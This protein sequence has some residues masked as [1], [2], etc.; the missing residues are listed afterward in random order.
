MSA[1]HAPPSAAQAV[2]F[3]YYGLAL[4][5]ALAAVGILDAFTNSM[6][7]PL[8]DGAFYV[9]MSITGLDDSRHLAA[10]FA[11]RPAVPMLVRMLCEWTSLP[12]L[13]G[14]AIVTRVAAVIQLFLVFALAVSFGAGLRGSTTRATA[15]ECSQPGPWC[16]GVTP[17]MSR[18][19]AL[20]SSSRSS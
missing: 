16:A 12:V 17:P 6:P 4:A 1:T 15:S 11:Y 13:T 10:P 3:H 2:R 7:K 20:G 8:Y 5:L 9:Q 19:P 18:L 14:Y